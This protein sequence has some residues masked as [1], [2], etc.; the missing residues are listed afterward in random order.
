MKSDVAHKL[1]D[2][3]RLF[4]LYMLTL[5]NLTTHHPVLVQDRWLQPLA[6]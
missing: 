5:E 3:T 4:Y 1:I 6:F 2:D